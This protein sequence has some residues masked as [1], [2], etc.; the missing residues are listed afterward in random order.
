MLRL[1]RF[2]KSANPAVLL[3][4][5]LLSAFD[6]HAATQIRVG[7]I[8]GQL[9][10]NLTEFEVEAGSEVEIIFSNN[11]LMQHNMLIVAPG[12]LD[13]VIQA[14]IAL[15]TEELA[16]NFVPESADVLHATQLVDPGQSQ[17]LTF[18]APDEP[19]DYPFVCTF[20][21]HSNTMRGIMHVKPR[22]ATFV[23][24]NT[25]FFTLDKKS[26]KRIYQ[27]DLT[28]LSSEGGL[29]LIDDRVCYTVNQLRD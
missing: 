2:F 24:Y 25:P 18:T 3:A 23:Y 22:G 14:A 29:P 5:G 9:K 8:P 20:I 13:T 17:T 12:K 6:S 10:Y 11:G 19:D 7:V 27:L 21:G 16:K 4:A 1:K 15:G 28:N 26:S